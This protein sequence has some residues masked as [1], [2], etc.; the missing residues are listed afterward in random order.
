MDWNCPPWP[1]TIVT[2]CMSCFTIGG[3][4]KEHRT[5]K[6]PPTRR[7]RERAKGDTTCPT[8][9]QNPS[10]WHPYWLNKVCTTRKDSES[11][12]LAEDNLETN[13]ITIKPGTVSHVAEQ[14]SWVPWPSC[15]PPGHPFPRKSLALS[16]HVSPRT[17][18][19]QV[20]D[21]S[22]ILGSGRVPPSCNNTMY[23]IHIVNLKISGNINI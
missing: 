1:G 7:V 17:I 21:K 16:P 15:S 9:S 5:N 6:P 23:Y 12:W 22:P 3:P 4:G 20:S 8:A 13:P 14:F 10:L 18:H 2:I 19:F 11:E